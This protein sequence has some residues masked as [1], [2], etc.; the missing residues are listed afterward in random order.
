MIEAWQT[1]LDEAKENMNRL[2]HTSGMKCFN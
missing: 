2:L 1:V